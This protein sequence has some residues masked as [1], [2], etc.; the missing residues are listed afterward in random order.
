MSCAGHLRQE[1]A[2]DL[3][4]WVVALTIGHSN[5]HDPSTHENNRI[6]LR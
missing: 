5:S 2:S 6:T 4:A 1:L 3:P